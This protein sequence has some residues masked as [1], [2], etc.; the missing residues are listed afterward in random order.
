[1]DFVLTAKHY[2][3]HECFKE[4]TQTPGENSRSQKGQTN[5]DDDW[6]V[7]RDWCN[8]QWVSGHDD[9]TRNPKE[10]LVLNTR[11]IKNNEQNRTK[12][13]KD[14]YY[15]GSSRGGSWQWLFFLAG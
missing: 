12:E 3:Y 14:T 7:G 15:Y 10:R 5:R 6:V 8:S 1:M 13:A 9:W 2:E 4:Y 11:K